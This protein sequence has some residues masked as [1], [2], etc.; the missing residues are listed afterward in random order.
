MQKTK[1]KITK[2][3]TKN[4]EGIDR[5]GQNIQYLESL[6]LFG[7]DPKFFAM[8]IRIVRRIQDFDINK[9]FKKLYCTAH[10]KKD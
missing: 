6:P 9:C 8:W 10:T 7:K 5:F 3:G 2:L 1:I 4:L